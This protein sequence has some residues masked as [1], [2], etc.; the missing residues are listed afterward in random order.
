MQ[1]MTIEEKK[2]AIETILAKFDFAKVHAV[3]TLTGHEWNFGGNPAVPTVEQLREHCVA[4]LN[5]AYISGPA[6]SGGGFFAYCDGQ[7]VGLGYDLESVAVEV[8]S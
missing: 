8:E 3:M 7:E 6:A 1:S 4:L 5:G 2:T